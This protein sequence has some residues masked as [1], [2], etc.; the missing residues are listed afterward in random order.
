MSD[1]EESSDDE[2]PHDHG[3]DDTASGSASRPEQRAAQQEAMNAL[4]P[5]IDPSEYG[6]MPA[7]YYS[8]SQRVTRTTLGTEMRENHAEGTAATDH[9]SETR[10]LIRPPLLPRDEFEGVDSYDETDSD[11]DGE[12]DEDH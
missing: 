6:K 11:E 5:G 8:N 4:V 10:N 12:D 3:A 7:A 1:E 9:T 2:E